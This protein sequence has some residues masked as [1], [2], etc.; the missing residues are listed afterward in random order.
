M[1]GLKLFVFLFLVFIIAGLAGVFKSGTG[2]VSLSIFTGLLMYILMVLVP[3]RFLRPDFEPKGLWA[4]WIMVSGIS[5]I[6]WFKISNDKTVFLYIT[7]GVLFWIMLGLV[8]K[9]D[10][11]DYNPH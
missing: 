4:M 1:K 7:A 8:S 5:A 6:I 10:I 9:F 2:H 3:G 11:R